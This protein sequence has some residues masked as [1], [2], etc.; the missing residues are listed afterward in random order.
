MDRSAPCSPEHPDDALR[1]LPGLFRRWELGQVIEA[2]EDYRI[3]DAGAAGD[4]TPLFAI[5]RGARATPP[6]AIKE[7]GP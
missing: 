5:Y 3:K 4:G 7:N 1:R 6:T 2:G